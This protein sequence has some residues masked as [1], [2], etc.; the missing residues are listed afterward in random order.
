MSVPESVAET[1]A[2][3]RVLTLKRRIDAPAAAVWRAWTEP[4]LL[5]RWFAPAPWTVSHAELDLRPG[6]ANLIVMRGPDGSEFPNRGVYLEIVPERRLVFTDAYVSAWEPAEHPFM[7]VTIS[8]EPDEAWTLYSAHVAHWTA[9][10]RERHEQMG[11]H[12]GWK[13][14]ADQLGV[15]A[16]AI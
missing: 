6:G 9:A 12:D 1:A 14:C 3:G 16:Q 4:D 11:F 15:V 5:E 13:R 8:L 2:D 7:T 10:D